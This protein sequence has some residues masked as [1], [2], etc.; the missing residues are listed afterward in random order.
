MQQATD[1]LYNGVCTLV[2]N[3]LDRLAKE[4][5]VPAF[6]SGTGGAGDSTLRAQDGERLLKAVRAVWDEHIQNMSKL[7]DVLKYMVG[8]HRYPA[9]MGG[10]TMA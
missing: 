5:I 2:A 3:N 1:K 8:Y 10:L 4:I 7:R 9:E 6:P